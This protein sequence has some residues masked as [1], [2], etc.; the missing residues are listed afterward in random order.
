[1]ALSTKQ[2]KQLRGL[3]HHLRPAVMIGDNGVTDNIV[4]NTEDFLEKL[5]LIKVKVSLPREGVA[6]AA[7]EL[8]ARTG[9]ELAGSIGKVLI[10]YRR[11]REGK[12]TI[13]LVRSS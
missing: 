13:R 7:T 5:E 3:A 8:C 10:I 6:E 4:A 12:P 9:A 2:T 11:R 1:M